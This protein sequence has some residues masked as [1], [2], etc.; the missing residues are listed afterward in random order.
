MS[1]PYF[2]NSLSWKDLKSQRQIQN[3]LMVFKSSNGLV[4]EYLTSKFVMQNE[5]NY[6]L[7]DLV[8]KLVVPF[9]RPNYM[10]NSFGYSGAN[11]WNSLPC[12]IREF[13]SLNQF[14]K[15]FLYHNF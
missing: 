4:P 2:T 15:R 7:R 9:P 12:N 14:C 8:N 1:I 11:L 5:S 3:A 13:D 10:K 6:A